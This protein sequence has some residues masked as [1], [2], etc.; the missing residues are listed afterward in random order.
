VLFTGTSGTGE[1]TV[2]AEL[3][4]RLWEAVLAEVADILWDLAQADA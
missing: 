1:S 2:I 4:A 3:G